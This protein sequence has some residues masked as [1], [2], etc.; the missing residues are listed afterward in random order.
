VDARIDRRRFLVG[1]GAVALALPG[2]TSG[3]RAAGDRHAAPPIR[4]A[5]IKRGSPGFPEAAHVYNE[6]FDGVLPALVARPLDAADVRTAVRWG[7]ANGVPLRARSGGH[8]Y[9]GYSTREGGMVVDLR[10]L[11]GVRVDGRARTAT[12]GAGSQ[13][14]DVYTALAGHGLTVPAGSCPSV[15]IA[16]HALGGGMGLAAREWGLTTDNVLE[17]HI[18]T[19]DGRLRAVSA[20]SDPDLYWALRGGGGGN[21]GVVTSFKLRVHQVPQSVAAFFVSWPWAGAADALAA[22]Q[23][24][25]PHATSRLTSVFHLTAGAGTTAVNVSGQYIGP[26]SD[27]PG[28]LAPL[29]AVAGASVSAADHGYLEAQ[30]IFAGCASISRAACHTVGTRP[31]GTLARESFRAKSD[32]LSAPLPTVARDA[33][34]N[35]VEARAALPGSGAVLFDSYSGAIKRVPPHATAFVHR[36]AL[37]C[38]QYLSYSGG[39]AWLSSTA[40]TM[41]PYVSGGAYVNYTDPE[42]VHWQHAYYGANYRRL[43]RIRRE[44][45]PYH[46][47]SFPQAI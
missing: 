27:L 30:L 2:R 15:G 14:I 43:L 36:D 28:L 46:Y 13:L 33:L 40:R 6:R 29:T 4:G 5:V 47:F 12:V 44:V 19:A 42:L 31:G 21:F 1:A 24:W 16:G 32:Y 45:D 34:V 8:S 39:A 22:W 17:L 7:I 41:R 11:R 25:A 18:V 9:A 10:N 38:V 37:C 23:G 3:A 35:A 26:S 20:A